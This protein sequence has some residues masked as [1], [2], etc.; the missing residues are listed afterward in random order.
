MVFRCHCIVPISL[1][2]EVSGTAFASRYRAKSSSNDIR[3]DSDRRIFGSRDGICERQEILETDL[4][5]L[6]LD[7]LWDSRA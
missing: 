6:R 2:F 4:P 5:M 7:W 3:R 1:G